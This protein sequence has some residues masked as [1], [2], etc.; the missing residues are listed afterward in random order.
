MSGLDNIVNEIRTNAK[1]EAD[2]I[3]KEADDYCQAYMDDVKQQVEK[4]VEVKQFFF[5]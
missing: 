2:N 1:K 5:E 3:L 4:E